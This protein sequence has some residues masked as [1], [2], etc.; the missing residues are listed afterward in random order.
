MHMLIVCLGILLVA[1]AEVAQNVARNDTDHAWAREDEREAEKEALRE[2]SR[3]ENV[4][5]EFKEYDLNNDGVLDAADIR[6]KFGHA[7]EAEMLFQFFADAD[8][9][10]IG[11]ITFEEYTA[12]ILLIDTRHKAGDTKPSTTTK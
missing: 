6:S 2:Q 11:I 10:Q 7:L 3:R 9:D 12:Y 5:R 1:H 8:I 4:E